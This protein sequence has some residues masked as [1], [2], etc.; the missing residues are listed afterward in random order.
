MAQRFGRFPDPE[1]KQNFVDCIRSRGRPNADIEEGHRSTLL[2]QF[3]NISYRLSGQKLI[4]DP[5]TE[6]FI[7]NTQANALLKREYRSP[8]VVP[9]KV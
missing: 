6:S 4:V 1:H 7:G 3:G 5:K 8:W 2:C 9:D